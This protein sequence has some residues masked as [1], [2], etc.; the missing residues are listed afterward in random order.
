[1]K[2]LGFTDTEKKVLKELRDEKQKL[3]DIAKVLEISDKTVKVHNKHILNKARNH[4]SPL[5]KDARD[6][7]IYLDSMS[8]L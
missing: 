6:V 7:S 2:Q 1:M 3:P 4:L 5:F 8:I